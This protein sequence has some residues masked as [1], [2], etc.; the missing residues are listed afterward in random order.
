MMRKQ[1]TRDEDEVEQVAE[2]IGRGEGVPSGWVYDPARTPSVYRAPEPEP[3]P[4]E[5]D[6][7]P[8]N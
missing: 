4:V 2:R 8:A 3:E 7:A 5:S 6:D 1:P